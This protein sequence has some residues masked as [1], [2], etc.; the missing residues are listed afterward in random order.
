MITFVTAM[1]NCLTTWGMQ[2]TNG[3]NRGDTGVYGAHAMKC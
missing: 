1:P 2:W 3:R